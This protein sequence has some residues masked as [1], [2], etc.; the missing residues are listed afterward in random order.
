MIP[1]LEILTRIY[2][3]GV[4]TRPVTHVA[5]QCLNASYWRTHHGFRAFLDGDRLTVSLPIQRH[6]TVVDVRINVAL[7]L[8]LSCHPLCSDSH[9]LVTARQEFFRCVKS[10]FNDV[11]TT[12][13]MYTSPFQTHSH[14]IGFPYTTKN[15]PSYSY[16]RCTKPFTTNDGVRYL[17]TINDIIRNICMINDGTFGNTQVVCLPLYDVCGWV[18]ARLDTHVVIMKN[19]LSNAFA[20]MLC[21]QNMPRNEH[22]CPLD[23]QG[24]ILKE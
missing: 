22:D 1:S 7:V 18:L 4:W 16:Q 21:M 17:F 24:M 6:C 5:P 19:E 11:S 20:R 15:E 10:Y 23:K 2:I 12:S 13:E 3:D 9:G 14:E 8:N